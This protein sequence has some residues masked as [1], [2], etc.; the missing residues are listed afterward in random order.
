MSHQTEHT[1]GTAV[2]TSIRSTDK[3]TYGYICPSTL[4]HNAQLQKKQ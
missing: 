3:N 2:L 1:E 4:T